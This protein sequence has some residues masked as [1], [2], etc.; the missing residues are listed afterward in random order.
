MLQ[1]LVVCLAQLFKRTPLVWS[2]LSDKDLSRVAL[3][4]QV[5]LLGIDLVW[6]V[7]QEHIEEVVADMVRLEDDFNFI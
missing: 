1:R 7:N 5:D 3:T 6:N 2:V 4:T